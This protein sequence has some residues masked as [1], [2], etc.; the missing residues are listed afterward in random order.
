MRTP[1]H[2]VGRVLR[3]YAAAYPERLR[4]P[5]FGYMYLDIED[6]SPTVADLFAALRLEDRTSVTGDFLMSDNTTAARSEVEM[7]LQPT[8]H[9][10]RHVKRGTLP[11][12][13]DTAEA[14]YTRWLDQPAK[15]N[16]EYGSQFRTGFDL[17]WILTAILRK[18]RVES[19]IFGEGVS[20]GLG[21]DCRRIAHKDSLWELVLTARSVPQGGKGGSLS[22]SVVPLV[23][24]DTRSSSALTANLASVMKTVY[25][26]LTPLV[27][28]DD[29]GRQML[30]RVCCLYHKGPC[31]VPNTLCADIYADAS[32]WG[33]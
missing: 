26:V 27:A 23:A 2:H 15:V 5:R 19:L 32:A 18:T 20:M 7:D 29:V 4:Q 14:R 31:V 12:M 3:A 6:K 25:T 28:S 1:V 10:V 30:T 16:L 22:C 9:F 33:P 17:L 24:V 11:V 13:C 21:I 8:L